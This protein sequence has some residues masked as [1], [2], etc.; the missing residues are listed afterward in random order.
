MNR[1][2]YGFKVKKGGFTQY[3]GVMSS[4]KEATQIDVDKNAGTVTVTYADES[5]YK[6]SATVNE[7][8]SSFTITDEKDEWT[9]P[10]EGGTS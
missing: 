3:E 9:E 5:V 4:V 1:K 10:P 6:Y 7:S 2:K 8:D